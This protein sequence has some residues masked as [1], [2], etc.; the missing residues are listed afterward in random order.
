MVV[1]RETFLFNLSLSLSLKEIGVLKQAEAP[2]AL[3]VCWSSNAAAASHQTPLKISLIKK[4]I[5]KKQ[6]KE[7]K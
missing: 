3:T 5:A 4:I 7:V 1:G 2:K 6:S